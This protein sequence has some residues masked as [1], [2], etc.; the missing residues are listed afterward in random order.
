MSHFIIIR[1][2]ALYLL[3]IIIIIIATG[4]AGCSN[5]REFT[6][7]WECRDG[8]S[9]R[10]V[11]V[12]ANGDAYLWKDNQGA[13]PAKINDDMLEVKGR[14]R[15]ISLVIEQKTGDLICPEGCECNRYRKASR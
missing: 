13:S 2:G 10:F 6:G 4:I 14:S 8:S 3:G 12:T 7:L 1:L 15:N 9:G 11:E 5:S